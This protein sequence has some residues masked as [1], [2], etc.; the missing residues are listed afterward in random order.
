MALAFINI[1]HF[2]NYLRKIQFLVNMTLY[3]IGLG[4]GDLH[5]ITL[6]GYNAVKKCKKVFLENYTSTYG[7]S[8]EELEA[9]FKKKIIIADRNL[10]EKESD[11]ILV[12]EN[13]AFLV[14]GDVFGATTHTDL[15]LRAK[16]KGIDVKIINN[17]SI[18]NAIGV[19][20]LD[21]YKFGQTTSIVFDD[22]WLPETP[23][24]VIKENLSRGLHTLCLLDIKV[25]EP[26]KTNLLKGINLAEPPRFM[27]IKQAIEILKKLEKKKKGK[28]IND[29]LLL[30]GVARLGHDNQFIKAGTLKELEKVDFGKPL[31]SLVIAGK[32]NEIEKEIIKKITFLR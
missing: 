2:N 7:S 30:M 12:G 19:T 14:V 29:S 3:M 28:V 4:L 10:V 23:Y 18:L 13:V 22:D 9:F 15:F 26:S 11:K 16:E 20:G 6:K 32:L 25:A 17:A 31:H 24:N 5:D 21:L 8:V 1:A 27:T